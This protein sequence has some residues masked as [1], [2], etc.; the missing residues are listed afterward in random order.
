V[1]ETAVGFKHLVEPLRRGEALIA[2]EESGGIGVAGH[3]PERDGILNTL[4]LLEAE[5]AAGEPLAARFAALER[6]GGWRHAYERLDLRLQG[7]GLPQRVA[8]ALAV[9]PA[10]FAGAAVVDVERL[11]G[12]KLNLEGDRWVLFRASGTEPVLRVYAEGPDDAAVAALLAA[13]TAF[14]D[15]LAAQSSR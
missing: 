15:A 6:E 9:D 12:V 13:A 1:V 10:D 3:V 14:V 7:D 8:E 5:L 11:D 4:L 2:G